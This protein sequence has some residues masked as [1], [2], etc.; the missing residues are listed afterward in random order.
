LPICVTLQRFYFEGLFFSETFAKV[1]NFGKG[2]GLEI[3]LPSQ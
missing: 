1:S 2:A 3:T